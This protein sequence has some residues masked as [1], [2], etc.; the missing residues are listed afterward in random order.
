MGIFKKKEIEA[1]FI[2]LP[3]VESFID[4]NFKDSF[5]NSRFLSVKDKFDYETNKLSQ[6]SELLLTRDFEKRVTQDK[7]YFK[8]STIKASAII[9]DFL[10]K[11]IIPKSILKLASFVESTINNIEIFESGISVPINHLEEV[12]PNLISRIRMKIQSISEVMAEF[13]KFL[14][15]EKI[16]AV[17]NIK[18]LLNE[19]YSL[20]DKIQELK[21][22]RIPILD[23]LTQVAMMKDRSEAR[24]Q[25]LRNSRNIEGLLSLMK[26][27]DDSK[28]D[29]L[30]LSS[31]IRVKLS[32]IL[33][34]L[35]DKSFSGKNKLQKIVQSNSILST[36]DFNS[37]KSVVN[38]LNHEKVSEVVS[39]IY[40][41]EE[42]LV[43]LNN[44]Y[45]KIIDRLRDNI[46]YLNFKEQEDSYELWNSKFLTL[47]TKIQEIDNT[48]SD[49][50]INFV[51]QKVNK[52]LQLISPTTIVE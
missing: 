4:T 42:K 12:M 18:A 17:S 39:T 30:E 33:E 11:N 21:D 50:S 44:D 52:E 7:D 35:I 1:N 14:Q 28:N 26:N 25:T 6:Y 2:T 29:L 43:K 3:D 13:N 38:E 19:F 47:K 5:L 8:K 24:L 22:Q 10:S 48:L 37:I 49:I 9:N 23:E 46:L 27:R 31:V 41:F 32:F 15:N 16:K 34:T 36:D 40:G 45:K 20:E 51:I